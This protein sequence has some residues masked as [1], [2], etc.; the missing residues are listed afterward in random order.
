MN[1]NKQ[2]LFIFYVN[3]AEIELDE[4][5]EIIWSLFPAFFMR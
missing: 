3:N 1:L 2:Y 5:N 4:S